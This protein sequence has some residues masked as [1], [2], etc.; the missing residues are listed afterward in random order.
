MSSIIEAKFLNQKYMHKMLGSFSQATGL[1]TEA[2]NM[3]GK[4]FFLP[5]NAERCE[6]CKFVRSQSKGTVKCQESY[7]RASLEAAKWQEPYFFRCHA[8][9]VLWA[10]PILINE[11]SLGSIICGQVLMWEPDEFYWEELKPFNEGNVDFEELKKLVQKLEIVSPKRT[12]AAAD[13]LFVVVNH[14]LKRN[15]HILEEKEAFQEQLQ[16]FRQELEKKKKLPS[17]E[18]DDYEGYLKKER[19]FL[20]YIRLGDRTRAE[21][22]LRK[23]LIDLYDKVAGDKKTIKLRLIE[24][25]TLV[26][27]AAVEGGANAERAMAMLNEFNEG[28]IA[29]DKVEEFLFKIH[30]I[31]EKLLEEIFALADKKHLSLVKEARYFMMENYSRSIKIDDIAGHLCISPSH[32]SHLF[33]KE[34]NCTV[35]DY[36]TRVRVEKAVELMKKHELSVEQVSRSV[37]FKNQSYLAKVFKKYI[38]VSPMVYRNSLF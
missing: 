34:L 27:R 6:F 19:N 30:T 15:I 35:N 9:L 5:G 18:T 23:L 10:V 38:G 29:L 21:K 26:S 20:S 32:L 1:Y 25:A 37:G 8:G 28:V 31:V 22:T 24:L 14:F 36:L 16:Q 11:E 17:S 3:E 2:V 13:M 7:K 12:Q 33:R 4:T